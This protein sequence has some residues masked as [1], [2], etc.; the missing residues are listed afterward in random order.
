M[1][2][3]G[4]L[5]LRQSQ[6]WFFDVNFLDVMRPILL[7]QTTPAVVFTPRCSKHLKPQVWWAN[8]SFN[9]V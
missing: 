5:Q 3:L 6:W 4:I 9:S 1:S 7:I 2:S 8:R